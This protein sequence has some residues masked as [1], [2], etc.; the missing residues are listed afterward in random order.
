MILPH[1]SLSLKM[2]TVYSAGLVLALWGAV[3]DRY[4]L[5]SRTKFAGQ[6]ITAFLFALFGY[7]FEVLHIPGFSIYPMPDALAVVITVFWIL[8]VLNAFNMVDGID[9]LAASVSVVSF[10]FICAAAALFDN[11]AEMGM[12]FCAMGVVA[13]FLFFNWKPA[14]IYLGDSGSSGL[15]MFIAGCLVA[16]GHG[17]PLLQEGPVTKPFQPFHY[18]IL[19]VSLFIA[20]PVLEINLSVFR[21]L[22]RGRPIY[23]ADQGHIH[24]RLLK[25]GWSSVGIVAVA[26]MV[27]VLPGMAALSTIMELKGWASWYLALSALALGLGLP[28]LGFLDFLAP[29]FLAKHRPHYQIAHHFIAMQRIKLSMAGTREEVLALVNQT[30]QE[31][32]VIA[33]RFIVMADRQLKGGLDYVHGFDPIR[34]DGKEDATHGPVDKLK[35]LGGKA[36]AKWM[37]E[38]QPT[39]GE[40]DMEYRVITNEF[41]K[42]ALNLCIK[43]GRH[44]N[45][46]EISSL[47]E[48]APLKITGLSLRR[49][50]QASRDN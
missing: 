17:N 12:A 46:L 31:L 47:A 18:Q 28:I 24:H 2:L 21:R 9:G 27:S 26:V 49:A 23:M 22:F 41:M 32:G 8:A 5:S 6:F 33:C 44:K 16:L 40:L 25:Q 4:H 48:V 34:E 20:Y 10:F 39:E 14:R 38:P 3:D 42:E 30:C 1:T 43:L 15:G 36:A 37:F 11:G 29:K 50:H 45:T 19:I 7:R 13:G 35:L